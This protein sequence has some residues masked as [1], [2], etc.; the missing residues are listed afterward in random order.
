VIIHQKPDEYLSTRDR[1]ELKAAVIQM[2]QELPGDF[3]AVAN[4]NYHLEP[5][6]CR[7]I[8]NQFDMAMAR[9]LL[10]RRW[11]EAERSERATWSAWPEIGPESGLLHYNLLMDIPGQH[12]IKFLQKAPNVWS[13]ICPRGE[14]Y[15]VPV[16]PGTGTFVRGYFTKDLTD[17]GVDAFLENSIT[18]QEVRRK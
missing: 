10:G 2:I 17:D 9:Q 15:I 18:H 1:R 12:Q 13:K 6:G 11:S 5:A 4:F 16:E 3:Y 7:Q 14:F 8:M